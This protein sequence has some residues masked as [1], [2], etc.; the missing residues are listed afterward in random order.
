M[1]PDDS[2]TPA[3]C[4]QAC[5]RNAQ[6]KR[7]AEEVEKQRAAV[8]PSVKAFSCRP[9]AGE[10]PPAETPSAAMATCGAEAVGVHRPVVVSG[11]ALVSRC[12][13]WR[14]HMLH[15]MEVGVQGCAL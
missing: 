1:A 2:A 12:C 3:A 13:N 8:H 9:A 14:L 5:L 4:L 15:D 6:L 7:Q 11:A 10:F